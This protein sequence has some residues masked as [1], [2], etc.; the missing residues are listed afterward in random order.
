[1][2][3]FWCSFVSSL[4]PS[5][6]SCGVFQVSVEGHWTYSRTYVLVLQ[7]FLRLFNLD[8][9]YPRDLLQPASKK[10]MC[11]LQVFNL[12]TALLT[13]MF[14]CGF[15]FPLSSSHFIVPVHLGGLDGASRTT[16]DA[17]P[18]IRCI[19]PMSSVSRLSHPF[20]LPVPRNLEFV[21][22][23]V[24]FEFVSVCTIA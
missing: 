11:T 13:L 14:G 6:K 8:C 3:L 24:L 22:A 21:A 4:A 15:L 20:H 1:M 17:T 10:K 9:R 2:V 7:V 16:L 5:H 12:R 19:S 23:A 18:L